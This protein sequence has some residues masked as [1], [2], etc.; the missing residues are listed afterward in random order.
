[1]LIFQLPHRRVQIEKDLSELSRPYEVS[2]MVKLGPEEFFG[3]APLTGR[4][5]ELAG[6]KNLQM[7]QPTF[8]GLPKPAPMENDFVEKFS[9][10]GNFSGVP[11]SFDGGICTLK[12]NVNEINA[13]GEF[14]EEI[15]ERLVSAFAPACIVPVEIVSMNGTVSGIPF[16]VDLPISRWF[17]QVNAIRAVQ[18]QLDVSLPHIRDIP[19]QI[20]SAQRYLIQNYRLDYLVEY[21][22]QVTGERLLNLCKAFESLVPATVFAGKENK[23]DD[24]IRGFLAGWGVHTNY[25]DVLISLRKLRSF[26][27][28]AHIRRSPMSAEAHESIERFIPL[29]EGCVKGLVKI[30]I[31]KFIGDPLLYPEEEN[32]VE[33]PAAL[34]F[35]RGYENTPFPS[36]GILSLPN[37]G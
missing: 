17:V 35:I 26:L 36:G 32:I 6:E 12:F 2:L 14:T 3:D 33:D 22:A 37:A 23:Q 7:K 4:L 1:M 34:R 15:T 30:A 5:R 11:I 16:K 29:A 25:V 21:T 8:H 24:R 19:R 10:Q 20:I 18:N 28:V 9:Y 13:L 31:E 27:D